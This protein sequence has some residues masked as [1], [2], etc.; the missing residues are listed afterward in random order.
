MTAAPQIAIVARR[1]TCQLHATR[2]E[3]FALRQC[4]FHLPRGDIV[5]YSLQYLAEN[6]VR[7]REPLTAQLIVEP[8]RLGVFCALKIIDPDGGINDNH[9]L[10]SQPPKTRPVEIAVPIDPS[11]Q[12]TDRA[13]S[14][15]PDQQTQR[16][17]DHCPFGSSAAAAHSLSHQPVIN[18]D[19][20]SHGCMCKI[21]TCLCMRQ[22][23]IEV[24][25]AT[26]YSSW[27]VGP[28]AIAYAAG[29]MRSTLFAR[30]SS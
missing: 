15:G 11:S 24:V 25:G 3:D 6:D 10:S 14:P 2:F 28:P 16:L 1:L 8:I 22:R 29:G 5:A 26:S 9:V 17:V 7:Q 13:L 12:T 23:P 20:G 27:S 19:V 4:F 21:H 30:R 18:V